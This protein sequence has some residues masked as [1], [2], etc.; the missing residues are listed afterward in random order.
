MI[1]VCLSL[2]DKT[3]RY[4]KFTG[5][6]IC[7]IFENTIAEV[8]VHILHDNTLTPDNRDKF[9]YL[10]G[11][12]GQAIKFYNVEQLCVNELETFSRLI[13]FI[14]S[15]RTTIGTFYKFL[16][17][18]VLSKDIEKV[19]YLDADIVVN[20]DIKELWQFEL[21][22]KPLGA[23]PIYLQDKNEAD[24]LERMRIGFNLPYLGLVKEEDY[25]NAGVFVMNLKRLRNEEAKILGGMKFRGEHPEFWMF[26]QCIW[27]YCFSKEYLKLPIKFNREVVKVRTQDGGQVER[28]IY[29]FTSNN[30][31]WSFG[32]DM[33]DALNRLWMNYFIKTPW[34]DSEAF[35]RIH[36]IVLNLHDKLKTDAL[37][38]SIAMSDKARAFIIHEHTLKKINMLVETF[39]IRS[40][41]EILVVSDEMQIEKLF[42][43]MN[44]SRGKK[45]FFALILNFPF[46]LLE[47]VG[48]VYGRDIFNGYDLMLDCDFYKFVE[49]M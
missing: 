35:G 23:V 9:I 10:A 11:R 17:M 1:H 38:L 47:E 15:A 43:A 5:T 14:K 3:G 16:I 42:D 7:S 22:D 30:S 2:Y 32:L 20:L 18:Y 34:F 21:G 29:H 12:Y 8:T 31:S 26:D 46:H 6:T 24:G 49:A 36:D 25:F 4:S 41:E 44:A 48:F 19:I 37:N 40:D 27:N 33:K 28:K 45:V 13:P 39:S